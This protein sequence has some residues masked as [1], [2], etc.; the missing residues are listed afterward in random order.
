MIDHRSII[1]GMVPHRNNRP[2]HHIISETTMCICSFLLLLFTL[3]ILSTTSVTMAMSVQIGTL[4]AVDSV[5]TI[6]ND[7]YRIGETGIL[8][9]TPEKPFYRATKDEV[10]KMI[11]QRQILTLSMD[12]HVVGCVKVFALPEEDGVAEWGC[13]AVNEE[14][15]RSGLGKVLVQAAE[16]HL[17]V[18]LGCSV[19]QIELLAP[20]S[21]KHEHKERLRGWY[22]RMGYILSKEDYEASTMRLPGG[23][24]LGDRFVL[25]TDADF[26]CYRK[27]L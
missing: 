11:K 22:Q 7:A 3:T 21:W 24:L 16:E 17:K 18:K 5:T 15:K 27:K 19:A 4:E 20:S 9:D 26:T 13:L 10:V 6:I 23:A 8:V 14:N 25:A 12:D 1:A 2:H